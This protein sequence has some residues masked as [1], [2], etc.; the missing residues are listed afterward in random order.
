MSLM[1]STTKCMF[2]DGFIPA[3]YD[4]VYIKHMNDHH[5]AFVNIKFLFQISLLNDEDLE[6]LMSVS[7]TI[8]EKQ[9]KN[10]NPG[11]NSEDNND[12]D[13]ANISDVTTMNEFD[14]IKTEENTKISKHEPDLTKI[15]SNSRQRIGKRGKNKSWKLE[16]FYPTDQE[17]ITSVCGDC[18]FN[19]ANRQA[20]RDHK[21]FHHDQAKYECE[22]CGRQI[23][24]KRR[25]TKHLNRH[26]QPFTGKTECPECHKKVNRLQEHMNTMHG[27]RLFFCDLCEKRFNSEIKLK[28]HTVV[29]FD[30]RPYVCRFGCGHASKEKGNRTK[31]EIHKHGAKSELDT[32]A[33]IESGELMI[34]ENLYKLD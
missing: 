15:T 26:K 22:F 28:S 31:H 19:A 23:L 30:I 7:N 16:V 27:E 5:R 13:T 12:V 3:S 2:C 18:G 24:G 29:H 32:K 10:E 33:M 34:D 14:F 11:Y 1:S 25:L 20:L 8:T 9:T 17:L 21:V 6:H 4:D